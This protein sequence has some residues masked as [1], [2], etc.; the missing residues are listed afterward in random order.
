MRGIERKIRLWRGVGAAALIGAS[1][2]LAACGGEGGESGEKAGGQAGVAGAGGEA[3]ESGESATAPAAAASSAAAAAPVGGETGEAGAVDAY[4]GLTGGAR[5]AVRFQH[6]K[7]FLLAAQA[8]AKAG[9]VEEAGVLVGQ[10]ALE[11]VDAAPAELPGFTRADLDSIEQLA[12]QSPTNQKMVDAISKAAFKIDDLQRKGGGIDAELV[13]RMLALT[14]GLYGMV[15]PAAGGVDAVEYQHSFGAV[16]AAQDALAKAG[17]GLKAKDPTRYATAQAEMAKLVALWP[18]P[19][20]PE[21]PATKRDVYA[22]IARV[23]L[24]LSGM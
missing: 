6:L 8:S 11:V 2:S 10:G 9:M 1:L 7:G 23:E 4:V 20:A 21:T 16:L 17:I 18:G 19:A 12:F 14:R 13:R 15:L 3:G 5:T 24:A 22:Q